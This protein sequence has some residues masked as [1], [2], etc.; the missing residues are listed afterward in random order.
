MKAFS[1]CH[2]ICSCLSLFILLNLCFLAI[3]DTTVEVIAG[4]GTG[5]FSDGVATSNTLRQ[6]FSIWSD[7]NRNVYVADG[8]NYRIRK[9]NSDAGIIS[10]IAGTGSSA[11]AAT[12]GLGTATPVSNP[13]GI[14]GDTT[15]ENIYFTDMYHVWKYNTISQSMVPFAGSTGTSSFTG[16]GN[17]ALTATFNNPR[18]LWLVTTGVLFIADSGNNRVRQVAV[19]GIITTIA[20]DGAQTFAG[21]GLQAASASLKTPYGVY[22]DT[23]GILFIADTGNSAVRRIGLDGIISTIAGTGTD[24]SGNGIQATSA[25]LGQIS[26]VRGDLAGNLFISCYAFNK[27]R[28]IT[29]SGIINT[30]IGTNTAAASATTGISSSQTAIKQPYG[31][32][33][34]HSSGTLYFSEFAFPMIKKSVIGSV[35]VVD[36]SS[37]P[38]SSPSTVPS[39]S[40][41][42]APTSSPSDSPSSIPSASPSTAPTDSPTTSPTATPSGKNVPDVPSSKPSASPDAF[43]S[44]KPSFSPEAKPTAIPN[45]DP[46]SYPT[47]NA[48]VPSS[49]PTKA[50]FSSSSPSSRPTNHP[51]VKPSFMPTSSPSDAPTKKPQADPSAS[52]SV[53]PVGS[54][55]SSPTSHSSAPVTVPVASPVVVPSAIATVAPSLS[56]SAVPTFSPSA[57]INND[58]ITVKGDLIISS[59]SSNFLN[60]R[61]LSTLEEA[62]HN[63]TGNSNCAIT[64]AELL[65]RRRNLK[66]RTEESVSHMAMT[67]AVATYKFDIHF[68]CD[69]DMADYPVTSNTSYVANLKSKEIKDAVEDGSFQKEVN[70]LA[71]TYNATQL[72]NA[73]CTDVSMSYSVSSSSSSTS[74]SNNNNENLALTADQITGIVIGSFFFCLICCFLTF[75]VVRKPLQIGGSA[76]I[77]SAKYMD[78]SH[79]KMLSTKYSTLG[80]S[81]DSNDG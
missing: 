56:P 62:L 2:F 53:S 38:S 40:P 43:P 78:L 21:D 68:T 14:I 47:T 39:A 73:N 3:A 75:L 12:G 29:T 1:M 33:Y 61:S 79:V 70:H 67:T 35:V 45:G 42:A 44:A 34:D 46:T 65:A 74:S 4:T 76:K 54:P 60:N 15:G 30:I 8:S 52:P 58:L 10:T 7:T 59:I 49:D 16:D 63:I 9:V 25:S 72:L 57:V 11:F 36:P 41:Y 55:S 24:T 32:F 17:Q 64:L 71:I 27:I 80:Q 18:G 20:G 5:A 81:K 37:S 77:T 22:V 48:A 66:S 19:D 13:K 6:P 51:S 28:Q 31:L 50:P 69:Y 23:T 26:D